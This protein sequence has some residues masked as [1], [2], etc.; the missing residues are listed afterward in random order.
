[1]LHEEWLSNYQL[2]CRKGCSSCCTQSV[3]ITTLEGEKIIE[4]L[5]QQKRLP[6]LD[7]IIKNRQI[8]HTTPPPLTTN[9]FA[10]YCLNGI[11]PQEPI[12]E[13]WDFTPCPFLNIGICTIYPARPFGCRAFVSTINCDDSGSAEIAPL[14]LT[15]NTIFTQI[16]EHL[17]QNNLWGKTLDILAVNKAAYP[18]NIA[19]N[20]DGNSQN[21]PEPRLRRAKPMP[22]LLVSKNEIKPVE[23]I[24]KRFFSAEISQ[25]PSKTCLISIQL[26]GFNK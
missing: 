5:G 10:E 6:E 20:R 23:T 16:I 15:I 12:N 17:D 3:T 25:K 26:S 14:V 1:M 24:L 4:Y 2:A 11:E 13:E 9:E 18:L 19:K 8:H 7:L 21:A 22:G